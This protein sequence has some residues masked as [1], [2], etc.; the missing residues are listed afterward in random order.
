MERQ[1][2][3]A[4]FVAKDKTIAGLR[5]G[6]LWLSASGEEPISDAGWQE[7]L[8]F[9]CQTAA[10]SGPVTASLNWCPKHGPSNAQRNLLTKGSY[11]DAM[12][13]D[14]TRR[15]AIMSDSVVVRGAL[16]AI[17]W[18]LGAKF[19]A[20]AF[21]PKELPAAFEWT[22]EECNV[23]RAVAERAHPQLLEAIAA[24]PLAHSS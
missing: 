11:A 16:T 21:A 4:L 10:A 9:L 6:D 20:R 17:G 2:Q 23:D 3:S 24:P 5:V 13:I 18:L 19:Q 1:Q 22:S 15:S 8:Q 12:Q 7:M 14:K